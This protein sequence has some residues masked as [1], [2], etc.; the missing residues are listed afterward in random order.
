[1]VYVG[2]QKVPELEAT[3]VL[4]F[5]PSDWGLTMDW[6]AGASSLLQRRKIAKAVTFLYPIRQECPNF[7]F[8]FAETT[9]AAPVFSNPNTNI[10]IEA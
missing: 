1:M 10:C 2:R 7:S 8:R 6:G 3:L 5:N 9:D 4:I